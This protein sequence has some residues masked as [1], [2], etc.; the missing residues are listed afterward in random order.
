MSVTDRI[1]KVV[2]GTPNWSEY[3]FRT[4]PRKPDARMMFLGGTGLITATRGALVVFAV[5]PQAFVFEVLGPAFVNFWGIT[6]MAVGA[7]CVGIAA[8]GHRH[9]EWDR[10]AAF[11]LMVLWWTW[12]VLYLISPLW[13]ETPPD[14]VKTD[15]LAG[16]TLVLTGLVLSSGVILSIRKTQEIQ[17]RV[18]AVNRIRQLEDDLREVVSAN[19]VLRTEL[20]RFRQ[21]P[22]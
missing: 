13:P 17:L 16:S 15:L 22:S 2:Y 21:D 4:P 10:L 12:G 11:L 14:R 18:I 9:P 8:T 6:W 20:E 5:S 1:R 19:E 7:I 3:V